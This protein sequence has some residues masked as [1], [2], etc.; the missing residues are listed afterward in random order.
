VLEALDGFAELV[1]GA[2]STTVFCGVLD[3][4]ARTLRYS[5]AGHPPAVTV[6]AEGRTRLLEEGRGLPLAVVEGL[7]RPE[8]EAA[9]P[10]ASALLLY[11]D[12]LV[13]RRGEVVDEGIG[14]AAEALTA[15]RHLP[16]VELARRLAEQLLQGE[17]Q[18]DVAFLVYSSGP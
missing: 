6:S 16:P 2:A 3:P 11:T 18:D 9:L 12:G 1:P 13:E 4:A 7:A 15:G 8:S 14:R 5:S 10:P 17:R